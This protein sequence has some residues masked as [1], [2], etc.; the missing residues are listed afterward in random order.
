[1]TDEV[2]ARIDK[3]LE[4]IFSVLDHIEAPDRRR[5]AASSDVEEW[6]LLGLAMDEDP[7]VRRSTAGNEKLDPLVQ[8]ALS[9]DPHYLVRSAIAR[10]S[11][12]NPTVLDKLSSDNNTDVR[13]EVAANPSTPPDTLLR[14]VWEET[15][16]DVKYGLGKNTALPSNVME[17][18]LHS[19]SY[20]FFAGLAE[21]VAA[22]PKLLVELAGYGYEY[23]YSSIHTLLA[24]N[25][26]CPDEALSKIVVD[27]DDEYLLSRVSEHVNASDLTRLKCVCRLVAKP[28][29]R[30]FYSAMHVPKTHGVVLLALLSEAPTEI[31]HKVLNRD[32]LIEKV[33][34]ILN[35]YAEGLWG[36]DI[37]ELPT[38]WAIKMVVSGNLKFV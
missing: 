37:A 30:G 32:D 24:S 7:E 20:D 14:M 18:L 22:P 27:T 12:T 17:E 35:E 6:L 31:K 19:K 4:F 34:P 10:N 2:Q 8:D 3:A 11:W 16:E 28:G 38:A 1:M 9:S 5:L 25:P 29:G 15:D 13:Y 23:D 36:K 26:I 33:T 21:N